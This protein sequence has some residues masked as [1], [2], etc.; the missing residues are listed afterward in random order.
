MNRKQKIL[1]MIS[2]LIALAII[3]Y[4]P[5]C[6]DAEVPSGATTNWIQADLGYAFLFAPPKSLELPFAKIDPTLSWFKLLAE[7]VLLLVPIGIV[8]KLLGLKES[9]WSSMV[10]SQRYAL[11]G[12]VLA[13][14][15]DC[16]FPP[17]W[18]ADNQLNAKYRE[19]QFLGHAP[20]FQPP[21][22][23][24]TNKTTAV[25]IFWLQFGIESLMILLATGAAIWF[26]GWWASRPND[27]DEAN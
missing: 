10:A 23:I 21:A 18:V 25:Q 22:F 27:W 3:L 11:F 1:L 15:A 4:P 9:L 8:Y 5:W 26:C 20:F 12:G 17:W 19:M 13:F 7:V 14:M 24:A 2:T 16:I 6:I